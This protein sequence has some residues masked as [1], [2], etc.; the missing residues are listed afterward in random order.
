MVM[1]KRKLKTLS[2][3]EKGKLIR[4]VQKSHSKKDIAGSIGIS[5]NSLSTTLTKRDV[6][7][8]AEEGSCETDRKRMKEVKCPNLEE[9]FLKWITMVSEKKI[10][11]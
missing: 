9:A 5:S 8:Q 6:I 10:P 7:L 4:S 3:H 1:T 2:L 11:L